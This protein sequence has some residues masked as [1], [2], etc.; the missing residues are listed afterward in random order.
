MEA[1]G[2]SGGAGI[3]GERQ[4]VADQQEGGAEHDGGVAVTREQEEEDVT[5]T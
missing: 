1:S 2:K 5:E 4:P 3:H